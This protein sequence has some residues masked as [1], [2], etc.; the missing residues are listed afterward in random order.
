[1][2]KLYVCIAVVLIGLIADWIYVHRTFQVVHYDL[3]KPGKE[4]GVKI[5]FLTDLHNQ[6]YGK[7]N[8]KLVRAIK[9]QK[10]DM[11][12]IGGDMFVK[13]ISFDASVPLALM[14][15]LVKVAKVFYAN[16][17]HE[18]KVMDEWEETKEAF[19]EYH[20]NLTKA[21]VVYLMND[22][23]RITIK[24][25]TFEIIGLDIGLENYRK[26]WHKP[27]LSVEELKKKIPECADDKDYRILLA[28][29]PHF[30]ELYAKTDVELVLSGHVHG[31]TII[32]PFLGGLIASNYRLFPKYDFGKFEKNGTTMIL[33]KGLGE[34]SIKLRLFNIPEV[35]VVEL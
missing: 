13:G 14:E 5:V 4:E 29:N 20:E 18:K 26:I 2:V 15:Q 17:N 31:G 32:L 34:H 9:A 7:N 11:I 27:T 21:G 23:R 22:S 33:S 35:S 25:R 3:K 12:L 1:M 28:H 16:G 24:G 30:F 8:E 10:P 6:V 19:W